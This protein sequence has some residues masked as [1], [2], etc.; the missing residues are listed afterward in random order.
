MVE[1]AI[2]AGA[3]GVSIGRNIFQH[4][5]PTKMTQAISKIVHEGFSAKEALE[6][7]KK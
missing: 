6:I 7:L 1:G 5:D 2:E 4:D 3:S